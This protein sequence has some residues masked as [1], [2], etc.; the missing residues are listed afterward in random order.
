M[1]RYGVNRMMWEAIADSELARWLADSPSSACA[2]R[3]LTEAE[4]AALR[5]VNIRQIFLLGGHPFLLWNFALRMNG[6]FTP[7]FM[8]YYVS[9][10][11]G[12]AVTG[13]DT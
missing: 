1:S 12:L 13:L 4:Q 5:E 11:D 6:G 8:R 3:G 9:Q 7:E 10:L 2:E